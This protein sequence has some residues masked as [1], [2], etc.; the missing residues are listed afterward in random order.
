M[1]VV[2][3]EISLRSQIP[4]ILYTDSG[5]LTDR[6]II[7][8]IDQL[9]RD[10]QLFLL[11]TFNYSFLLVVNKHFSPFEIFQFGEEANRARILFVSRQSF[12]LGDRAFSA[13][14]LN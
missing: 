7:Q 12:Q 13:T 11:N 5:C 4:H 3:K 8:A 1:I 6:C 14:K 10:R 2:G 9:S